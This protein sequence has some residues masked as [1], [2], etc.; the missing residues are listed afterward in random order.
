MLANNICAYVDTTLMGQME[1]MFLDGVTGKVTTYDGRLDGS[2][3]A[4]N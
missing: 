4:S 2:E 3:K 1:E